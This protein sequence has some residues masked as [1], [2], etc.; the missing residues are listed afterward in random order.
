MP[1]RKLSPEEVDKVLGTG[2]IGSARLGPPSPK[3]SDEK[4][5][6]TDS[7]QAQAAV[8]QANNETDEWLKGLAAQAKPNPNWMSDILDKH[9]YPPRPNNESLPEPSPEFVKHHMPSSKRD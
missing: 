7:P 9:Q 8:P 2:V 4:S 3:N 1:V 5:A 6:R